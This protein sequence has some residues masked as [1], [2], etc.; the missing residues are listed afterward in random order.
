LN[1]PFSRHIVLTSQLGLY[2]KRK[3][4]KVAPVALPKHSKII[5]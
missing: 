3:D 4:K 2:L 5:K 1:K